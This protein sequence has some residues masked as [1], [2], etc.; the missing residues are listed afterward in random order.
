MIPGADGV[1]HRSGVGKLGGQAVFKGQDLKAGNVGEFGSQRPGIPQVAAGVAAAMAVEDGAAAVVSTAGADP[2]GAHAV[3]REGF[4]AH[5]GHGCDETA[6][7]HLTLSL[8]LQIFRLHGLRRGGGVYGF[9]GAHHGTEG[10]FF[11]PAAVCGSSAGEGEEGVFH[12]WPPFGM[13][14]ERPAL[15]ISMIAQSEEKS[16]LFTKKECFFPARPEC[17]Q[18]VRIMV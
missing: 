5:P 11:R 3:Q 10:A 4:P 14:A 1:L 17:C 2:G 12:R 9:Q 13:D 8:T 18:W 15:D 16:N 7:N 6:Q